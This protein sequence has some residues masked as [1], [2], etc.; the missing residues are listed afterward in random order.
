[1]SNNSGAVVLFDG[2][3]NLCSSTVRFVIRRD[4]NRRFRFASLQSDTARR[5][6]AEPTLDSIV[7]IVNGRY[8]RKSRAVLEILRR[9]DAPWPLLY[10][11]VLVPQS[12]SDRIY[13]FI[14]T[15]RY[16][17]FGKKDV[18]WMPNKEWRE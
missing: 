4:K 17:W 7:L 16:K 13:D 5:L 3:C 8:Y 12:I 2:L 10:I 14:G 15:H 11:F 18:C 6:L 9:L 1:M